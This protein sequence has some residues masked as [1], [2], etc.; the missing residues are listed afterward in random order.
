MALQEL[1][2]DTD[3]N[4][5]L[6]G[7]LTIREV[8]NRLA[9]EKVQRP[10]TRSS[11]RSIEHG[12]TPGIN[13]A[14]SSYNKK[15]AYKAGSS[16]SPPFDI[17][18]EIREDQ[19]KELQ[20]LP[21]FMSAALDQI[22]KKAVMFISAQETTSSSAT[23]LPAPKLAVQSSAAKT[24]MSTRLGIAA[25]LSTQYIDEIFLDEYTR[26]QIEI[27]QGPLGQTKS[28]DCML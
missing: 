28:P 25:L 7:H 24:E 9:C 15:K 27:L 21:D 8:V 20:E 11:C 6:F 17:W 22:Y 10:R 16:E 18:Q 13:L 23:T 1:V 4:N 12:D 2:H 5:Q 14:D 3:T 19:A 26:N